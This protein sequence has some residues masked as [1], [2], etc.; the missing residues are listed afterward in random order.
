[1]RELLIEN[2]RVLTM[3]PQGTLENGQVLIRDGKIAAV[4][5]GLDAP[6]AQVLDA[7]GGYVLPGLIDAHCHVG[8]YETAIGFPGDDGNETS[9]PVTPQLRAIDGVYPLD[10]EYGLAVRGGVTT[11]ATGPG[12]SNPIA[13]EFIAMKTWGMT[14]EDMVLRSPLAMKMAFGENPKGSF[15]RKGHMPVTR[16]AISA[17]IRDTLYRA[18]E[19]VEK[20]DKGDPAQRPGYD[21]RLEALEPVIRRQIPIKAHCHRADDIMTVLRIAKE[22]DL[23]VTLD[24]C[25]EGYL[26]AD[27]IAESGCPV[28]LGPLGGFPQKPEVALQS[29]EAAGIL[30]RAGVK[31]A[32][33]TD[34]PANHLWYLPIAAGLCV[35]AGLPEEEG[36]RAITSSAAEILSL[37][38]RVGSLEPG[39]DGDVAIFSGNPIRDLWCRCTAAVVDGVVRHG[40]ESVSGQGPYQ[41][42]NGG[43]QL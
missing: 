5:T 39:K 17:L 26:I 16:M 2:G 1:M 9:E 28:I 23:L 19:Y 8:I 35:G 25:T 18:R 11:V 6:E 37:Q 30:F 36:F 31:V 24:H 4:G 20:K 38:D 12:S 33:M 10:P 34:L 7:Q 3:G 42:N 41:K 22:L 27:K 43:M 21:I 32:I 14:V 13:G 29:L 40:K 15:G